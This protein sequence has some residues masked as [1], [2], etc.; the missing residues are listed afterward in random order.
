MNLEALERECLNYLRDV[1]NPLVPISARR[2]RL[3]PTAQHAG[4]DENELL[5]FLRTH[6]EVRVIEEDPE[7]EAEYA[8]AGIPLGPRAILKLRVPTT[9]EMADAVGGQMARMAESLQGALAEAERE[10]DAAKA[11]KVRAML[12]RTEELQ[13]RFKG[14]L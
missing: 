2:R 4:A 11:V 9:A 6:D 12:A 7:G 8:E 10:G 3:R 14:A 13:Q 5:D 1:S